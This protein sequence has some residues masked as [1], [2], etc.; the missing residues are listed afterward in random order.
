[1]NQITRK[2][3][4][5]YVYVRQIPGSEVHF[6]Y[7]LPLSDLYGS[8]WNIFICIID[9]AWGQDGWIVAEFFF[10]FFSKK[11]FI[12]SHLDRISLVKRVYILLAWSIKDFIWQKD[13][14]VIGIK[15]DLFIS[16]AE[17]ESQCVFSTI[18]PRGSLTF[19]LFWMSSAAFCDFVANIVQRLRTFFLARDQ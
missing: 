15:N 13:F 17:K 18:D 19:S 4:S 11:R 10:F 8:A 9:Q 6:L 3:K 2:R 7:C 14:A 5:T 12:S 16:R 1:M